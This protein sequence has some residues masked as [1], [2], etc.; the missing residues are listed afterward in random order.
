LLD[1]AKKIANLTCNSCSEFVEAVDGNR[2]GLQGRRQVSTNVLED[3][4][5]QGFRSVP[6]QCTKFSAERFQLFLAETGG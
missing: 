6:R 3:E 2:F 5:D 1:I 4:K